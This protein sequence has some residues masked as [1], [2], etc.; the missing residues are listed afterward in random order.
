MQT[1]QN[2]VMGSGITISYFGSITYTSNMLV[3][4]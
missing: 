4:Y 3:T 1:T 2:Q